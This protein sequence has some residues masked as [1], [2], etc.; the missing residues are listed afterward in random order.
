[1]ADD[2]L[3]SNQK[4]SVL[5]FSNRPGTIE[6][7]YIIRSFRDWSKGSKLENVTYFHDISNHLFSVWNFTIYTDLNFIQNCFCDFSRVK[8]VGGSSH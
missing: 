5:A 8:I 7:Y 6:Y 1:M 4:K 3:E 2:A